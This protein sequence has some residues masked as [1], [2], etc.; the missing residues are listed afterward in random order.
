MNEPLRTCVGCRR[1]V[2]QGTLLRVVLSDDVVVVDE[3]RRRPGRGAWVHRTRAC[4]QNAARGGLQR[5]FR[6]QVQASALLAF[7]LA[8]ASEKS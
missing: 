8:T 4:V 7:E 3:E 6:R 2:P 1:V 5:S